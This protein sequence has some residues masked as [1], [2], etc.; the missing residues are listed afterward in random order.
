MELGILHVFNNLE[1]CSDQQGWIL[2]RSFLERCFVPWGRTGEAPGRGGTPQCPRI[3]LHILELGHRRDLWSGHT[4]L[5]WVHSRDKEMPEIE[6]FFQYSG[7]VL[8]CS[9]P[10]FHPPHP[11]MHPT[12]KLHKHSFHGTSTPQHHSWPSESL[13]VIHSTLW[14]PIRL[15]GTQGFRDCSAL[16]RH[17]S[18]FQTCCNMERLHFKL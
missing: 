7:S 5:Q 3:Q 15:S 9:S 4:I 11:G 6:E 16:L 8:P 18:H 1:R 14:H 12:A 13:L 10:I 17:P 2:Q